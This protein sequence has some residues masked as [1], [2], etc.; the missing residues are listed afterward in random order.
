MDTS[1]LNQEVDS[2]YKLAKQDDQEVL[3]M[4]ARIYADPMGLEKNYDQALEW[5]KRVAKNGCEVAQLELGLFYFRLPNHPNNETEG[6]KWLKLSSQSKQL[7][8]WAVAG[9]AFEQAS[10]LV[11]MRA[12][13]K[14]GEPFAIARLAGLYA[15]GTSV[16]IKNMNEAAR[17]YTIAAEAGYEDAALILSEI[18]KNGHGLIEKDVAMAEKWYLQAL[19]LFRHS[20]VS[21]YRKLGDFYFD[22][23]GVEENRIE[24][25]KWYTK[26]AELY[27]PHSRNVLVSL[28]EKGETLED[29]AAVMVERIILQRQL[30]SNVNLQ[31]SLADDVLKISTFD[32][33]ASSW[34]VI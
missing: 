20:N 10:E 28:H 19:V 4:L 27:D 14:T 30:S 11:E 13:A 23:I 17:L 21:I 29:N 24:A 33:V 3:L 22:G 2:I 15:S 7:A 31:N 18:Y 1:I 25:I 8:I 6:L 12:L 32:L 34:G 9:V 26:A 16:V 5:Y